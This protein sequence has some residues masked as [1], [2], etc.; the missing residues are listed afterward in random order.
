MKSELSQRIIT[1]IVIGGV[2]IGCTLAGRIP[3][4]LLIAIVIVGSCFEFFR[5]TYGLSTKMPWADMLATLLLFGTAAGTLLQLPF[6]DPGDWQMLAIAT[7]LIAMLYFIFR[8]N[9]PPEGIIPGL[10]NLATAIIL[11]VIPG[12]FALALVTINPHL[13][14]IIFLLLWSNDVFA[15]FGGRAFG[16]HKLAP[17]ISPKKTWEGFFSG[18]IMAGLTGWGITFVMDFVD[19]ADMLFTAALVVVFGTLGDLLQ[20][21]VKRSAQVKDSGTIL[22]G[23]GGI[24]DRF[25]SFLGCIVPVAAY[26]L[27]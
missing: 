10:K 17:A 12:F 16:K 13:L 2:I 27:L 1:G 11:F 23:H 20:S 26:Y 22:P 3:A 19:P 5:M 8:I 9:E 21:A 25:D 15:Y 6:S 24:W 4:Y 14:L 7:A 18:L